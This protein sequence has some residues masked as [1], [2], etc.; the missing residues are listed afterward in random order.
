MK[1]INPDRAAY[2]AKHGLEHYKKRYKAGWKYSGAR[3]AT[4]GLDPADA[5]GRS[6]DDAWMDGYM[7]YANRDDDKWHLLYCQDH[8][9]CP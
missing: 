4:H 3:G 8:D 2:I 6:G 1:T 7:D 5:D 9:K